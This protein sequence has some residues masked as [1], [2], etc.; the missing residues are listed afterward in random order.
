MPP[1]A[2]ANVTLDAGMV[3]RLN[4]TGLCSP[5]SMPKSSLLVSWT[6]AISTGPPPGA[7]SA[8]SFSRSGRTAPGRP[9]WPTMQERVR[10][11]L[12]GDEHVP[13]DLA[14]RVNWLTFE[15]M[16]RA[17]RMNGWRAT[18]TSAAAA[19]RSLYTWLR[20]C[21]T[22]ESSSRLMRAPIT[23]QVVRA[24]GHDDRVGPV[25]HAQP[26]VDQGGPRARQA[27]EAQERPVDGRAGAGGPQPAHAAG[28]AAGAGRRAAGPPPACRPASPAPAAR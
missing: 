22:S 24:A 11:R 19:L 4:S 13:L 17:L 14:E 7:A 21:C 18:C 5:T 8:S 3:P 2:L 1:V 28:R 9:A 20:R 12:G 25:V 23:S 26:Q 27:A 6:S 16:A 15:K 10:H